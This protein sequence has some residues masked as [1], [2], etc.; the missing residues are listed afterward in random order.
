M[1]GLAQIMGNDHAGSKWLLDCNESSLGP[2]VQRECHTSA[3]PQ[4][5][6]SSK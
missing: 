1:S 3:K 4:P 6:K 2:K 5:S